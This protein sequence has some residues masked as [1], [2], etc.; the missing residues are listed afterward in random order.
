MTADESTE[1]GTSQTD[2]EQTTLLVK[3]LQVAS[4]YSSLKTS[5]LLKAKQEALLDMHKLMKEVQK[6]LAAYKEMAAE[7]TT[8]V[9]DF[10][11]QVSNL[12]REASKLFH[13]LQ[14]VNVQ[15]EILVD[16][17]LD[18]K[19]SLSEINNQSDFNECL[20]IIQELA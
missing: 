14:G 9:R 3:L 8:I 12:K 7:F 11:R 5:E 17:L 20:D 18:D 1:I 6:D 19:R 4:R 2:D 15:L 13:H 10:T 16:L